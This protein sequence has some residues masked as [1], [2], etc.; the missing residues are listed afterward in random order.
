LSSPEGRI[1][2]AVRQVMT[3]VDRRVAAG[4]TMYMGNDQHYFDVAASAL[5]AML[6][7]VEAAGRGTPRRILDFGCGYGRVMRAMR[8]AFPDAELLA[9][10]VDAGGVAHCAAAFGARPIGAEKDQG[11]LAD[12]R[13]V[14]L[15]WCGSVLTHLDAA[16]WPALLGQ[17]AE[18]LA[19]GGIAVVTTHG[20]A[21]A[22]RLEHA[23]DYCLAAEARA[24]VLRSYRAQGFGYHD[25]PGHHGYGLSM[26]SA[27]WVLQQVARVPGLRVI[28][29]AEAGWDGHQD[30]LSL[31][32]DADRL[33]VLHD[34]GGA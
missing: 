18:M 3:A 17:W 9:F 27:S 28:G 8:A 5:K 33:P 12:V 30:V 4:D 22:G 29:Y 32:R 13:D 6:L 14:D 11:Q 10:D 1:D 23:Y 24:A 19:Q 26:S 34:S 25:L 20:R 2:G 16:K 21:A 7:A 31:A 15:L